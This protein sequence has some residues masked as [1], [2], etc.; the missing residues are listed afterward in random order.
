MPTI[1]HGFSTVYHFALG[2]GVGNNMAFLLSSV[3]TTCS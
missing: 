1:F 2:F 3:T